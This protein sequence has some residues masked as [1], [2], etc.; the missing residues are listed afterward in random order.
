LGPRSQMKEALSQLQQQGYR[1]YTDTNNNT[2]Y[3]LVG[4]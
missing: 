2:E 3:A 1:V 4:R